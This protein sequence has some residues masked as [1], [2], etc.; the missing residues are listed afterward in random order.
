MSKRECV[1]HIALNENHK[2]SLEGIEHAI[3][4]MSWIGQRQ[5][6]QLLEHKR[7]RLTLPQ[8]YT[9]LYLYQVD[10]VSKMSDLAEATHQSAASLTGVIDRLLDKQ[11]VA[12]IRHE[13]DRRQVM[14]M[15]TPQGNALIN[16]IQQIRHIQ[17]QAALS[18]LKETEKQTLLYL[19]NC[20]LEGMQRMLH[21]TENQQ[22]HFEKEEY[23]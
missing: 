6:M 9:L 14:V 12:R 22:N 23:S 11:L 1:E 15:L 10:G 16:E 18:Q 19:L 20:T 3:I 8:F 4:Q 17:I 7:F 13:R 2:P 21:H 5:F